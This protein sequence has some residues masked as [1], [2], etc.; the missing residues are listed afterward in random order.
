MSLLLIIFAGELIFSLPF[1]IPRFFRPTFIEVFE[2]TNTQ[3]GDVFAVYGIV[4]MLCY[5]PG[6]VLADRF[7]ARNL[8]SLS[9]IATAL[10]GVYLATIP[11]M[12][13]LYYLFGYWGCTSILLFWS[14]MIKSTRALA[15][16]QKQG[17]SFGL[18]DGGRG[19]VA[20]LAAS[21]GVLILS[22]YLGVE[23]VA[24]DQLDDFA[25]K[26]N[27]MTAVI[28]YY[29]MM[30][31]SA[32]VLIWIFLPSNQSNELVSSPAKFGELIAVGKNK[33]VWLQSGI[34]V[35]AYCGY[36]ALDNYGL[37]ANQVLNLNQLDAASL[38]AY[39]SYGRPVA[40]VAAGILAD[41]WHTGK[42]LLVFFAIAGLSFACA[43]FLLP[44]TVIVEMFVLNTT[45]TFAAVY[46]L[47]GIYFALLEQSKLNFSTTGAAVGLISLVGYTPDIFF[48]SL[49][50]RI[51][52]ANPGFVGFQ[53][54]FLVLAGISILGASLVFWL[55]L[56]T[57]K[58][59]SL[60]KCTNKYID[61]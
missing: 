46:A 16:R 47:R 23:I 56:N 44:D 50:G 8:M 35:C 14:A 58:L 5:F 2:L 20:S 9:L 55:N 18:L 7:G 12:E 38:T 21:L 26:Q 57:K 61:T 54:Y 33:N 32:G 25:N 49:T 11:E 17:L 30:T 43:A 10:G 40:A 41:K 31:C 24:S 37:Y 6:G 4:A 27:A 51:L 53:N 28:I 42:S 45:L 22:L 36:K 39:A 52:D 3:L 19:L 1:H 59:S 60:S 48:S 34:I 13:M 29:S 15:G